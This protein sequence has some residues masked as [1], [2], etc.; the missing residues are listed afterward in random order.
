MELFDTDAAADEVAAGNLLARPVE[1]DP[2]GGRAPP[3][4]DGG[5]APR[6]ASYFPKRRI[7]KV[8]VTHAMSRVVSR[9]W[10]ADPYL[11]ETLQKVVFHRTSACKIVENS[12]VHKTTLER[13][14][15]QTEEGPA[16]E[17]KL[18][19]INLKSAE[20]RFESCTSPMGP[21]FFGTMP[22]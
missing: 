10:R 5:R 15:N 6:Q 22:C 7:S 19:R 11:N 21:S 8:D 13:F 16:S 14:I 9:P 1:L 2:G 12:Y 4:E 18:Q 17:T 20:H 3:G